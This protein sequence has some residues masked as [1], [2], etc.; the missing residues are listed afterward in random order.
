[1][2]QSVLYAS[3]SDLVVAFTDR[4]HIVKLQAFAAKGLLT[5]NA[6]QNYGLLHTLLFPFF[7]N[8]CDQSI[9]PPCH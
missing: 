3:G 7:L 1:M 4:H 2:E 6:V 8:K 9:F 5:D